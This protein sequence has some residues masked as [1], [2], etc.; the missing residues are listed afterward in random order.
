MATSR[1]LDEA[2]QWILRAQ[3]GTRDDG[4]SGGYTFEDGWLP[5]YPETTGYIIPSLLTYAAVVGRLDY[6]K[7]ALTMA[8]WELTVQHADGGFPGHFVDRA[9]PPVVFNTGQIIFGLLAAHEATG[10]LRFLIAARRAGSW[11]V[12]VQDG[13]GAWR[14]FDYRNAVHVYNT[15]TA[16]ALVELG[17]VTGERRFEA[18][19]VRHLDWALGQQAGN[20]FFAHCAFSP[21]ED[22]FVHTIAY[23]TQGLLEAGLRLGRRDYVA[24]AELTCRALLTHLDREGRLPGTFDAS[25]RPT[26][27]YSCVTGNAQ[28]AAQW[29]RLAR[30]TGDS[31][32]SDGARRATRFLKSIHDC[33]TANPH[34]RGAVKGS[35]PIWGRYLFGSYPNWAAKFFMDALLMELAADGG[36]GATVRCW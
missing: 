30:L 1:H 5:S 22:P 6:E 12:N 9:H 15:R 14:R 17:L 10:D 20:G 21:D 24:A 19:G 18:T 23:T 7:A 26:A 32:F 29:F 16:W 8:E 11:L 13:D 31:S 4:V 27:S 33:A 34:I 2:A 28:T 3:A 35:H 36:H 25:W